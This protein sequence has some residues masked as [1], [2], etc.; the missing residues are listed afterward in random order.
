MRDVRYI[1]DR[2]KQYLNINVHSTIIE[3]TKLYIVNSFFVNL[4]SLAHVNVYHPSLRWRRMV[5]LYS[6]TAR[7]ST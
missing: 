5:L 4:Q 7:T 1:Y 2:T 3:Y 6:T